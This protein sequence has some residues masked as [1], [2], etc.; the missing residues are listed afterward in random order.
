MRFTRLLTRIA[1]AL[2]L[3]AG[4]LGCDP[5]KS[6]A[7]PEAAAADPAQQERVARARQLLAEA[8]YPKGKGF[9]R[10]EILYNTDAGHERV[11]TAI[12]SMWRKNLGIDVE[13]RNTEWKVYLGD[14]SALNYQIMRRGWIADYQD[15]YTFIEMFTSH[16]GNNNT[17]WSDPEY[18]RLVK[19]ASAEIDPRKRF[20]LLGEAEGILMRDVPVM[21]LY[22]YFT[23]NCWKDHVKGLRHNLL[24]VHPLKEVFA[25][26]RE[27]L[28]INNSAEAQTLDPGLARG[29]IEFRVLIGLFEGL[30]AY[31]PGTLKMQPGAAERWEVS[32]DGRKYAFF[33]R[34][35]AWSDG[36]KVT[37][38]D[39]V[40][41]WTRV[42]DPATPTDYAHAL[43]PLKGAEAFNKGET[44]DPSGV[45]VRA[46]DDRTLDVEIE[47]PCPFFLELCAFFPYY[48]VPKDAIERHGL[49]WTRPENMAC[50]GPYRLKERKPKE[51]IAIEKNP[52]YWDAA[53]VRQPVIRFLAAEDRASAWNYYLEGSCDFATTL[54]LDQIEEIRRRPDYKGDSY[55][56]TYFY[57][58]N[59]KKKPLDQR[60][61]RLALALAVDR[62]YIA[63]R[64]MKQGQRPA[65]HITPPAWPEYRSPR[66]DAVDRP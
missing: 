45:G 21:P 8:G 48:P 43:Y 66:F 5:K 19:E 7:P 2:A 24:D 18:D 41:A 9:P 46:R 6:P 56:A 27:V 36:R 49:K 12:Q 37:A 1:G 30:T 55:L 33:L 53:R 25:E 54:P 61:V 29:S 44:K 22:F 58:F 52:R 11:A 28:V 38:H 20:G 4:T 10:L 47:N 51:F 50:N 14:M 40:Y 23:Q 65:F 3:V 60:K 16:S 63:S 15:P 42:L 13:L 26:G 59:V 35:C 34:D 17:G 62:E 31:E 57:S 32:P 39:F 64:I